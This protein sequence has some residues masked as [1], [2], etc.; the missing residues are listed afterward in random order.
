MNTSRF[1]NDRT[2]NRN[3][4]EG[5]VRKRL[6]D[7]RDI[8]YER[9][10][11]DQSGRIS[12]AEGGC[13]LPPHPSVL[14]T[15]QTVAQ[16]LYSYPYQ[17]YHQNCVISEFLDEI[18][19]FFSRHHG[20]SKSKA[21]GILI[22]FGSSHIFDGL[23]SVLCE[24]G[25]IVLLPESY[26]HAFSEWP[27]KHGGEAICIRTKKSQGFK[28]TPEDIDDWFED[29][30]SMA[31]RVK[32]LVLTNPTTSGLFYSL[33]ELRRLKEVIIR[34]DIF[35]F[36]DEVF[37][38]SGFPGEKHNSLLSLTGLDDRVVVATSGSKTLSVADIR[39][40][41]AIGPDAVTDAIIWN[42]EHSFTLVSMYLQRLGL[43]IL[44]TPSLFLEISNQECQHR[45]DLIAGCLLELNGR[46]CRHFGFSTD[47]TLVT[48]VC[49]PQSGHYF[50]IDFLGFKE[51]LTGDGYSISNGENLTRYF[52]W[53]R[54]QGV[55]FSSGHSKGHDDLILYFS[56]AQLGFEEVNEFLRERHSFFLKSGG[57]MSDELY[58]EGVESSFK[59][60]REIILEAFERIEEA[61]KQLTPRVVSDVGKRSNQNI[62]IGSS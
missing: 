28:V 34:R 18:E 43:A 35:V 11:E 49:L 2:A 19:R 29:N 47:T 16:D 17:I 38:C 31:S 37:A 13:L 9:V 61:L 22:G 4:K 3:L 57:A 7:V 56:F 62:Q 40:G 36:C 59:R 25:S 14:E 23:L 32:C 44:K 39:L 5:S 6:H 51:W 30:P 21:Q 53:H 24:P 15:F 55:C 54:P 26:Y 27:A 42:F 60:G 45:S 12:L 46:L 10:C 8:F 58:Y 50:A 1:L 41:W 52:Y 20:I 33:D 48:P